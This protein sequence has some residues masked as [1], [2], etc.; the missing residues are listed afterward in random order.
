MEELNAF[1]E[2]CDQVKE[3]AVSL[4]ELPLAVISSGKPPFDLGESYTK[5]WLEMQAELAALSKN[6]TQR[7][8]EDSGHFIQIERPDVVVEEVLAMV[9]SL[10]HSP[11][12]AQ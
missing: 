4:E 11:P 9:Q 3:A 2:T 1:D 5:V 6:G 12:A 7:V 8:V 10:R